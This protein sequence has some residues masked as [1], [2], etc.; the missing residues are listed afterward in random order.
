MRS[1][2]PRLKDF[3]LCCLAP[4]YAHI[5][6]YLR[7]VHRD[8]KAYHGLLAE[9]QRFRGR[10]Y[11]QDGA[12]PETALD[13]QRRHYTPY[14]LDCW[15]IAV[16]D[17]AKRVCAVIRNLFL[18]Q[19]EVKVSLAS[20]QVHALLERIVGTTRIDFQ[21]ALERYIENARMETPFIL[22][23]GGWAVDPDVRNAAVA[24][25]TMATSWALGRIHGGA[26][27]IGSATMRHGSATMSRRFGGFGIPRDP[28]STLGPFY[29]SY[30]Q[31]EMQILGFDSRI[32]NPL[33]ESTVCDIQQ[34]L[35]G[36][37]IFVRATA[38][39]LD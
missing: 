13:T 38:C 29:D 12:I 17:E 37:P 31:C 11:V 32:L 21:T 27:G 34:A 15:H 30:Y 3:E 26:R 19:R 1:L 36:I 2:Y 6:T 23:T 39:S 18:P 33:F 14:D 5:P 28:H 35:R 20:L 22:E 16:L 10:V 24:P 9:I 7:C 8:D 25:I 4:D